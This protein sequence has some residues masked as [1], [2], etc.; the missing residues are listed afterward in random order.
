[1]LHNRCV[2]KITWRGI[3]L[4][5]GENKRAFRS[6]VSNY[7]EYYILLLP[8]L[9]LVVLFQYVPLYGLQ[10]AFKDFNIFVGIKDSPFVGLAHFSRVFNDSYFYRVL[11]NTLIISLYKLVFLF[12]LPIILA[13]LLNE[14]KSALFRRSVQTVVYLPHFLSWVIVSGLFVSILGTDGVVNQ[15]ITPFVDRPIRFLMD[16]NWFRSVLV[17]TEGW[18]GIGWSAIVYLAAITG[19]DPQLYEAAIVDGASKF[20]RIWHITLPGIS[21]TIILL[22]ILN[23][24]SLLEAGFQQILVMYNPMVYSVADIIGTYFYRVGLGQMNFSYGAAVGLF[25]SVVAFLLII[26]G[27]QIAK[28]LVGRSIW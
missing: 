18:K 10:I 26:I 2:I 27:N 28:R 23:I 9:A 22:L 16:R 1:M 3:C 14:V 12:P 21:P 19:I 8:A 17:F 7:W 13:I 24:G 20:R 25:N 11:G 15:A 5:K 6:K 4:S